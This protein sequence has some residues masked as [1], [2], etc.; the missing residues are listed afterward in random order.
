MHMDYEYLVYPY[1]NLTH[2]TVLI[3]K[4]KS[5]AVTTQSHM[6]ALNWLNLFDE[7]YRLEFK[8]Y[9]PME[10][11]LIYTDIRYEV[12]KCIITYL[13]ERKIHF[14]NDEEMVEVIDVAE[15]FSID[16]LVKNY[17]NQVYSFSM[18]NI[19]YLYW[20]WKMTC[21]Y[22]EIYRK[23][24]WKEIL[25]C[26]P[27]K[28][29]DNENIKQGF[30]SLKLYDLHIFL[31]DQYLNV[32]SE[33]EVLDMALFWY[34]NNDKRYAISY[35]YFLNELLPC[36]KIRLKFEREFAEELIKKYY[37][38]KTLSVFSNITLEKCRYPRDIM[39]QI[40]GV[41]DGMPFNKIQIYDTRVERWR[42]IHGL[43]LPPGYTNFATTIINSK[44]YISGGS[45]DDTIY[46]DFYEFDMNTYI[47]NRL[48]GMNYP[49]CF[50]QL[51]LYNNEIYALGGKSHN[52]SIERLDAF[53]KYNLKTKVWTTLKPMSYPRSDFGA[54]I[55][56]DCLIATGGYSNGM[57]LSSSSIYDFKTEEWSEG[58][59]MNIPRKGHALIQ[60]DDNK[61]IVV[62]GVCNRT[63]LNI[64]E[65]LTVGG[66]MFEEFP[67]LNVGRSNFAF[68]RY[69]GKIYVCGG[70]TQHKF[71]N[72]CEVFDGEKWVTTHELPD[73]ISTNH[74]VIMKN[75]PCP[76]MLLDYPKSKPKHMLYYSPH[77]IKVNRQI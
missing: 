48:S 33:R 49:R 15:H 1:D 34:K 60:L 63:P 8:N 11:L 74:I 18:K 5:L 20:G 22:D 75:V 14:N 31:K 36:F 54:I 55:I 77:K 24:L 23:S 13:H 50:H 40:G 71:T 3:S 4:D 41:R 37:P 72:N 52:G 44:V 29:L 58:P 47:C 57:L 16:K 76:K 43:R 51:L 39:L 35:R 42:Y 45:K 70:F 27:L 38:D 32:K 59:E 12:L 10:R 56:N 65:V 67:S 46:N 17:I 2:D 7:N 73:A 66:Y 9:G 62:G 68:A 30:I 26:T 19:N 6:I 28:Y 64:C 61:I 21:K 25:Y 53:E 69:N